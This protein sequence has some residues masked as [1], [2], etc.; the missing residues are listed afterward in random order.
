MNLKRRISIGIGFGILAV[1]VFVVAHADPLS[2][3]GKPRAKVD[4]PFA[5]K[6][7]AVYEK[8]GGHD[9]AGFVIEN[10]AFSELNGLRVLAGKIVAGEG[11]GMGGFKVYIM[12]D[13]ISSIVEC[14]NLIGLKRREP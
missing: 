5:S 12:V 10:P 8:A 7:L 11:E 14:D 13:N 2:D 3:A 4:K 1:A 9:D 6:F